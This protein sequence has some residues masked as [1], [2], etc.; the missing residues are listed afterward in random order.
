MKKTLLE[1]DLKK[2]IHAPR[3]LR[4]YINRVI[5][6][7]V[8]S[9]ATRRDINLVVSEIVSNIHAHNMADDILISL[10]FG[11]DASGY[12][13]EIYDN[14]KAFDPLSAEPVKTDDTFPLLES[15]RGIYLVKQKTS[16]VNYQFL[17]R[18]GLN[19][20]ACHWDYK[21]DEHRIKILIIDDC[22][23]DSTVLREHLL[24]EYAIFL[25][26]DPME[27]IQEIEANDFDLI[28]CDVLMP[29]VSGI[30][31]Y[32]YL[33]K[34]SKKVIPF[35]FITSNTE[36][37][38]VEAIYALGVDDVLFKPC[39]MTQ[40]K[41]AI[42]RVL[43]QT[44]FVHRRLQDR[45]DAKISESLFPV[46]PEKLRMWNIAVGF[47]NTGK[48]GGDFLLNQSY[49]QSDSLVL[50]DIM[51]HNESAKFFSFAYAGYIRGLLY[52]N[53]FAEYP[54][55]LLNTISEMALNDK[56]FSSTNLTC[57]LL[58]LGHERKIRYVNAGHPPCL[59]ITPEEVK[60]IAA[61]GIMPGIL[62]GIQYIETELTLT[63][64][65]RLAIYTDGLF[66]SGHDADA[67]EALKHAI[68]QSLHSTLND[69]IQTALDVTMK[70][71]DTMT[72]EQA[73]DDVI[74]CLIE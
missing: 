48:G 27:A 54:A 49:D 34:T 45:I 59:L 65:S 31:L 8:K 15:H 58:N 38:Y 30:E 41:Q 3:K 50:V 70:L 28:V 60:P 19:K 13:L 69:D 2:S 62:E 64:Q 26:H 52:N 39:T 21:T 40:V 74:L 16:T 25:S 11:T 7:T 71:F 24:D 66:D 29:R 22:E 72:Q 35:I 17:E 42:L 57:C 37:E 46:V 44:R 73:K 51:G 10:R 18:T 61:S 47:R 9:P 12:W 32:Q 53:H 23:I 56:L 43:N 55:E 68:T 33:Q 4:E 20:L 1:V 6:S 63:G 14:G 5:N 67:R 36:P